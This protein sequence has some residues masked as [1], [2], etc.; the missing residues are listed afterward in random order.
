MISHLAERDF[1]I[2]Y[3]D[4]FMQ[5]LGEKIIETCSLVLCEWEKK[6]GHIKDKDFAT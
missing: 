3:A 5:C 1:L 4:K 2:S 6:F